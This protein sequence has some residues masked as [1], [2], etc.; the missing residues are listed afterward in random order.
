MQMPIVTS[1]YWNM[2]HVAKDLEGM[3]TMQILGENMAYILKCMAVVSGIPFPAARTNAY[4]NYIR[5]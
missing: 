2:V 3:Q 1:C 4:T 5:E